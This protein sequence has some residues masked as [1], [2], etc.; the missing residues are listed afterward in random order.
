MENFVRPKQNSAGLYTIALPWG[1]YLMG[2]QAAP[3]AAKKAELTG[4]IGRIIGEQT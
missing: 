1:G 2:I 3:S 4:E